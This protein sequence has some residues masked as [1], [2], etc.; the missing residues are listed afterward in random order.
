MDRPPF[1]DAFEGLPKGVETDFQGTPAS[2]LALV[3][4]EEVQ[5]GYRSL[6]LDLGSRA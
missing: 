3:R 1:G 5:G 4:E 2:L 6:S